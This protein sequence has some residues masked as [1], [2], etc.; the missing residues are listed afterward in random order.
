[1]LRKN[2]FI[3]S[4]FFVL[5]C[6]TSLSQEVSLSVKQ[7]PLAEVL[8]SISTTYNIKI[9]Y[10]SD[11]AQKIV[12]SVAI[13][14]KSPYEAVVQA[15]KTTDLEAIALGDVIV[16]RPKTEKPAPPEPAMPKEYKILGLVKAKGSSEQLP[17]ATIS[18]IGTNSG[19]TTNSDGF[20]AITTNKTDSLL[21]RINYIGFNPTEI[22]FL[23]SAQS[24]ILNIELER[25]AF[26]I[27]DVHIRVKQP[28]LLSS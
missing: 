17:Y 20:F 16:V 10:D 28:D 11:L 13:V 26:E 6:N 4:I 2:S 14:Q 22:S 9:A 7:R 5:I 15:L 23:P 24:E 8:Q 1:M 18:I 27:E 3:L 21:I 12:V 25:Q 19:T